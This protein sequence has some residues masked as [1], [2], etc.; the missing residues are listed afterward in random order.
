M[1]NNKYVEYVDYQT[2]E[3]LFTDYFYDSELSWVKLKNGDVVLGS[4]YG[5]YATVQ[6]LNANPK[7]K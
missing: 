3:V 6:W 2:D 4:R 7:P 1:E 5:G